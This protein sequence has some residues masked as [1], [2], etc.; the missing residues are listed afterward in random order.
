MACVWRSGLASST[1]AGRCWHARDLTTFR[2]NSVAHWSRVT[3]LSHVPSTWRRKYRRFISQ[4]VNFFLV[5]TAGVY[6]YRAGRI[7]ITQIS[8]SPRTFSLVMVRLVEGKIFPR[9]FWIDRRLFALDHAALDCLNNDFARLNK[10]QVVK[11]S[12]ERSLYSLSILRNF[13]SIFT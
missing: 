1:L 6:L 10:F 11:Y 4:S 12:E 7:A 2:K 8:A 3:R 5:A 13:R 9:R